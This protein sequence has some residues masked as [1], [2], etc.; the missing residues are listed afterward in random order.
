MSPACACIQLRVGPKVPKVIWLIGLVGILARQ[1]I[2]NIGL[3]RAAVCFMIFFRALS[4]L[5]FGSHYHSR[6]LVFSGELAFGPMLIRPDP[7][8][9]PEIVL[10]NSILS[11]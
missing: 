4:A 11:I 5:I 8:R 6:R 9:S 7:Q 10:T 2:K 3:T 1:R